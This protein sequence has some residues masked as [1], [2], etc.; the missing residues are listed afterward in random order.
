MSRLHSTVRLDL[1]LQARYGFYYAAAFVTLLWIALLYQLP[2]PALKLATPLVVF[3]ELAII[4]YYFIAGMVLFE[5]GERTIYALVS[6]PLRFGEY[7]GSKLATLTVM[8][9]AA[10]LILVLAAYGTDFDT[11]PL[12][13]GVVS[14]SLIS[15]LAGFITVLPFDQLTRYLIPS[16]LPLAL[17]SLP[18]IPFLDVWHNPLFYLFPTHGSLLLLGSSFGTETLAA[19]QI[20][21]SVVYGLLWTC[22]LAF[23]ARRMFDR[24]VA[25]GG[26]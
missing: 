23:A 19:W 16:Q 18:L 24:Y 11:V 8:A 20:L 26:R 1:M 12:I 9:V 7:L 10:S 14:I 25:N 15:M 13:L 5:K 17:M 3:A 6:T 22:G 21:Y 2:E 4:G